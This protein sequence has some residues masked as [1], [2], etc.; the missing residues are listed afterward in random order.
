MIDTSSAATLSRAEELVRYAGQWLRLV[1]ETAGGAAIAIGAGV[2]IARLARRVI[3]GDSSRLTTERLVLAR[4]L[5]L[6]LEFQLAADVLDTAMAPSWQEIG[7]LA[8]IAVI[9]TAL[10]LSLTREI[11]GEREEIS[12]ERGTKV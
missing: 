9:R 4:F 12:N 11:A 1:L 8:A 3:R 2:V 7:E 6:A 5:T 10:N